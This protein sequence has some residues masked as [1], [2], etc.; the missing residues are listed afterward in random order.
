M[1]ELYIGMISGTSADGIDAV[2]VD[3]KDEKLNIIA[4]EFTPYEASL[5]EKILGLYQPGNNEIARMGEMD[6]LLGKAFAQATLNLLKK[7][8][9]SAN[10]IKAI[11][12]HGQTIRHLPDEPYRFTLQIGNPNIIAMETGITTIADF[13]RKDL[14]YGGQGAPLVP[15]F[16]RSVF[17]SD[18]HDRIIVNIGGIANITL[19]LKNSPDNII[20]YDT[21]PGNVLM[22]VWI[23]E[24]QQKTHDEAGEWAAHGNVC[25]ELLTAMLA[26]N[27]FK[28]LPPKST[29]REYFHRAWLENYLMKLKNKISAVDVQATLTE[30]TALTILNSIRKHTKHGDIIVCGGGARNNYLMKRLQELSTPDF[31]VSTTEKYAIHPDWVEAVAFAWL[32]KQTLSRQ[33]GNIPSVTGAS[34]ATV[35]GGVYYAG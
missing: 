32:A 15:A 5:K 31:S 16:H 10:K 27:Y 14:A 33:P 13:R 23:H 8:S 25:N 17:A 2:L 4:T 26:D 7:H 34:R 22:D 24:Q 12:S 11:G 18:K 30:L 21:G 1:S 9:I 29:G 19:L 35:L 3:F 28:L 6:T 20:G